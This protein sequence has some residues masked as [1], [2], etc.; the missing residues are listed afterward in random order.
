MWQFIT[1]PSKIWFTP[2]EIEIANGSIVRGVFLS[3]DRFR[4]DKNVDYYEWVQWRL[5][6]N[7]LDTF[8]EE[9]A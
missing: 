3:V 9:F 1:P 8:V 4:S 7:S 6:D 2:C 5:V